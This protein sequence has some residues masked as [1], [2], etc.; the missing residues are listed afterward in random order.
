M[1]PLKDKEDDKTVF[2][3]VF[4]QKSSSNVVFSD[5]FSK[6]GSG[7]LKKGESLL[8]LSTRDRFNTTVKLPYNIVRVNN[9]LKI[10]W[11]LFIMILSV[12]NCFSL[13][14]DIAFSPF[15]F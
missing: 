9:I 4:S 2:N 14:V 10:R 12:W 1:Y 6:K 8:R 7:S 3:K 5:A 15:I 13:P 11:D